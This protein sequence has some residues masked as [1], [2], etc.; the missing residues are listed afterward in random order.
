MRTMEKNRLQIMPKAL[1]ER[2]RRHINAL[3]D[4]VRE[5]DSL[6]DSLVGKLA[7]WRE[8]RELLLSMPGVGA[9]V[10]HTLIAELPELG[11]LNNKQ[12]AALTGV[13]PFNRDSGLLRGKRRIRGG[14]RTVRTVLYL[15]AL[16]AVRFNPVLK[17]FYAR[18]L[19]AGKNKKLALTACV[20][21]MVVMLN[22]MLRDG[23]KWNPS[24]A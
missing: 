13:A 3:T 2:I 17:A 9:V 12:V 5:L 7:H 1:T 21:K 11:K 8:R 22:A 6:I 14:R 19:A 15:G 23:K 4:D 24:T 16:A 18:L 10:A 20:R